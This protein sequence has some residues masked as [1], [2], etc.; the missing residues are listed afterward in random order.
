MAAFVLM[1]QQIQYRSFTK[2]NE[3]IGR[4]FPFQMIVIMR[5]GWKSTC[6]GRGV[7]RCTWPPECKWYYYI[8]AR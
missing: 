2:L 8:T 7:L 3:R 6:Q 4:R 1:I 5:P